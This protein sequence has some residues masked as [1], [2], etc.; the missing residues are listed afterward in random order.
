MRPRSSGRE[1]RVEYACSAAGVTTSA[2]ATKQRDATSVRKTTKGRNTDVRRRVAKR[3]R[4][5]ASIMPQSARTAEVSIWRHRRDALKS[6]SKGNA[7]RMKRRMYRTARLRL[8][9]RKKHAPAQRTG[10]E[11][12]RTLPNGSANPDRPHRCQRHRQ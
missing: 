10:S 8:L 12:V 4:G 5:H 11:N 6:G 3:S 2:S 9:L 7:K 1:E